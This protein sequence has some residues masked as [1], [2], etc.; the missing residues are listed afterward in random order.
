MSADIL[1]GKNRMWS[2]RTA[3]FNELI[4]RVRLLCANGDAVIKE[5]LKLA[6]DMGCL[7]VDDVPDPAERAK[8][9]SHILTASMQLLEELQADAGTNPEEL[10]GVR[11]LLRLSR[12]YL[13][14]LQG[15]R[16]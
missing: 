14:D 9:A 1:F 10:R 3:G 15:G 13:T 8:L 6:E 5:H 4:N 11:D 16:N 12:E 7:S 2:A